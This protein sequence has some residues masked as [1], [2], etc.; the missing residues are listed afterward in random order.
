MNSVNT[1][2]AVTRTE[3]AGDGL[4]VGEVFPGPRVNSSDGYVVHCSLTSSTYSLWND[5][6][7]GLE[8]HVNNSR[9]R[10]HISAGYR[11]RRLRVDDRPR[12]RCNLN[13]FEAARVCWNRRI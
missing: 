8:G 7:E 6:R 10:F 13:G 12:G 4:I 3:S 5:T 9:R 2:F 1:I 11:C